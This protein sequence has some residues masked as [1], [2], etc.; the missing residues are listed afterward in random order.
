MTAVGQPPYSVQRGELPWPAAGRSPPCWARSGH[1]Q[2]SAAGP[3]A[4]SARPS[5][6]AGTPRTPGSAAFLSLGPCKRAREQNTK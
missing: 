2:C 4:R 6:A 1:W 3:P 5:A